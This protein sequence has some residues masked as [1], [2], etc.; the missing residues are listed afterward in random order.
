MDHHAAPGSL[1]R[2]FQRHLRAQNHSER[3]VGNC[4][5]SARL[6]QGV[7]EAATY[8]EPFNRPVADAE[9]VRLDASDPMAFEVGTGTFWQGIVDEV[10]RPSLPTLLE[11]IRAGW[12][13]RLTQARRHRDPG[14]AP[15]VRRHGAHRGGGRNP[16][17]RRRSGRCR[18]GGG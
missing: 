4:L 9:R 13:T 17:W 1:L 18:E 15:V 7:L 2:S 14:A 5:E 6:A 16:R 8:A 3:T 10:T 12:P 11:E